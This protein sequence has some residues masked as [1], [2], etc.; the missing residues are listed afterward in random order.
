M[1][2][3]RTLSGKFSNLLID[4]PQDALF[5]E[6]S[7]YQ[8]FTDNN[9]GKAAW[10]EAKV[11]ESESD[12]D[13]SPSVYHYRVDVLW[14]HIANL[15]LS[16]TNTPRFKYLFRVAEVVVILPHSNAE[17]ERLFSIVRKNKTDSRSSLKLDGTLLSI[18]TMKYTYPESDVPCHRWLPDEK[19]LK[20]A[21]K[22]ASHYN[23]D[24][25]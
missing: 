17:E 10:E 12:E 13:G 15:K 18:L 5:D 14:W 19:I 2:K 6:F 4:I 1:G 20:D 16:G 25:N 7:D 21:K 3:C 22:A 23:K 9:I 11:I 24:H 8:T